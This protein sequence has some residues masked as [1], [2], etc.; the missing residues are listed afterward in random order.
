MISGFGTIGYEPDV[1]YLFGFPRALRVGGVTLD[2]PY[3]MFELEKLNLQ[4]KICSTAIIIHV[5]VTTKPRKNIPL[6]NTS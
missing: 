1:H 2:I 4:T 6:S 5:F 3:A